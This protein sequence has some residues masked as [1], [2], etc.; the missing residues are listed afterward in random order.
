MTTI[1]QNRQEILDAD[2]ISYQLIQKILLD[3]PFGM[4]LAGSG[5]Q[6][7]LS[8]GRTINGQAIPEMAIKR[9]EK[10]MLKEGQNKI[11]VDTMI[12]AYSFGFSTLVLGQYDQETTS[13]LDYRTLADNKPF[14]NCVDPLNTSG[15]GIYNQDPLHRNFKQAP[16]IVTVRGVPFHSS[17]CFPIFNPFEP[18]LF[19]G[20]NAASYSFAPASIFRRVLPYLQ[21]YIR[22]D[23]AVDVM[24]DKMGV[25]VYAGGKGGRSVADQQMQSV[26]GWM[27]EKIKSAMSGNVIKI[28]EG[29]TVSSIDLAHLSQTSTTTREIIVKNIAL[30]SS[31]AY[32]DSELLSQLLGGGLH[33]GAQDKSKIDEWVKLHQNAA[34]PLFDF[35]DS[36]MMQLA[37]R[38]PAWYAEFQKN[39]PDYKNVSQDR[40]IA[41]W[42]KAFEY[43]WNSATPET[44]E[45]KIAKAKS[46]A[47]I[48]QGVMQTA[49]MNGVPPSQLIQLFGDYIENINDTGA[50]DNKFTFNT[51][52]AL[53]ELQQQ[54]NPMEGLDG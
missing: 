47:E 16:E 31:D 42:T 15:S 45:Q 22:Y 48:A 43:E 40:A 6:K 11:I 32:P 35:T 4:L 23:M 5:I 10:T 18:A 14:F 19:L 3:C 39:T 25:L 54:P 51:Q 37:W 27:I 13:P 36:I 7:A 30:N 24:I 1:A 26:V 17:R 9:L 29:E 20:W 49:S 53:E 46:K 28:N 12:N 34:E 33:N 41:M 44:D 50:L 52:E 8:V 21:Q 38:D 2:D